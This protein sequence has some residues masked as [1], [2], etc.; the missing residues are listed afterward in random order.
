[1]SLSWFVAIGS[2]VGGTCRYLLT[3]WVQHRIATP[4]PAGTLLVNVVG[5]LVLG[6][7]MRYA[8]GSSSVSPESRALLATGFCGGFTTFSTFSYEAVAL[9]EEADYGR[10]FWYMGLSVVLS[11]L[12]VMA[13]MFLARAALAARHGA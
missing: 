13:G 9:F 6:F 1:M 4:F 11:L 7:V 5:S 10:A 3:A 8:L 2:A 12:A